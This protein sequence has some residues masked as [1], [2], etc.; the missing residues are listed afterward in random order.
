MNGQGKLFNNLGSLL[1]KGLAVTIPVV[2]TAAILWWMAGGSERLLGGLLD[3]ALPQGWYIPGMGVIAAL[4][5]V[6]LVGLLS[7][8]LLFQK[9]FDYWESVVRRVPLVKTIY[10]AIKDFISYFGPGQKQFNKVVLV[11]LPGQSFQLLGFV[12]R[13]TFEELPFTPLADDP[14]S[15]YL[16]MSYQIGGYTL[17]LSRSCLSPVD[18]TF[19]EAMR[20]AVTAGVTQRSNRI[21]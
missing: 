5:L 13:E 20:L 11:Q 19:E 7:H 10:T 9:L 21:T 18:M 8:V 14:V 15:V 17:F 16:P 3:R 6:I 1:L 12:T 4:A 2:L